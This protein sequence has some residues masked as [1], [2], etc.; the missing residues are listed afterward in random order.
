MFILVRALAT[1]C[2][3]DKTQVLVET[4]SYFGGS[5][6]VEPYYNDFNI[7]QCNLRGNKTSPQTQYLFIFDHEDCVGVRQNKSA[8]EATLIVQVHINI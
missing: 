1:T 4:G 2:Q 7:T 3:K 5:I 8:I 6:S